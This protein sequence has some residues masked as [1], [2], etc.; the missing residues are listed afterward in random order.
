ME[1]EPPHSRRLRARS[2]RRSLVSSEAHDRDWGAKTTL[3]V[4]FSSI[5]AFLGAAALVFALAVDPPAPAW[6]WFAIISIIVLGLGALGPLAF[7]RTRV[8]AQRP[9]VAEHGS[10]PKARGLTLVPV[11]HV[12]VPTTPEGRPSSGARGAVPV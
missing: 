1:Q 7:E 10:L 5:G 3:A 4:I 11:E 2:A 8:S 12:V 9:A 6:M